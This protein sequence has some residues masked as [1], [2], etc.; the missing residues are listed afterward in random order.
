MAAPGNRHS[1]SHKGGGARA[2]SSDPHLLVSGSPGGGG[3]PAAPNPY[4]R[5]LLMALASLIGRPDA[6]SD[7]TELL[8][9]PDHVAGDHYTSR[10]AAAQPSGD[11]S[12]SATESTIAPG[13]VDFAFETTLQDVVNKCVYQSL[14][15][16]HIDEWHS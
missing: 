2:P 12:Y 3:L 4:P 5:S 7:A 11:M 1:P 10:R 14:I 6:D 15:V 9:S 8:P 13:D 16:V